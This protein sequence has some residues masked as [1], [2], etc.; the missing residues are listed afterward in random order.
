MDDAEIVGDLIGLLLQIGIPILLLLLT[1]FTG[2][3]IDRRHLANLSAREQ[4]LGPFSVTTLRRIPADADP[5]TPPTLVA[6]EVSLATD[7]LKRFF[8]GFRALIGGE[9]KCFRLLLVR[10]R[11]E[12]LMRMLEEARRQGYDAVYNV[13]YETADIGGNQNPRGTKM[14]ALLVYGTAYRTRAGAGSG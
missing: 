1:W 8:A 14:V 7:Y 11:R 3:L 12:A 6:G 5:A 9:V 10:A 2:K 4:A 13:R